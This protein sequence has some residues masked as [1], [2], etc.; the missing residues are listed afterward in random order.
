MRIVFIG[1]V[2]GSNG[3]DILRR[4]L[5]SVKKRYNADVCIVNGENSH[6]S[7]TGMTR[8]E[9]REI[10]SCGADVITGGNHSLRK[11]SMDLYEETDYILCPANF[12][13]AGEKCGVCVLDLGRDSI[14]VIN[15]IGSAFMDAHG[16]PFFRLD[17]I[18]KE[19]DVKN[20]LV[21][22][23]REATSEKAA[24]GWY[25]DGRVSRVIGTHTH[26]QTNDDTI[27]PG[28]TAYITDAGS[29][30]AMDSVLGVD[31]DAAVTKQKLHRPVRFTVRKG[32]GYMCGVF[33]E[34]DENG[35]AVRIE[36][37]RTPVDI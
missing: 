4:R 11:C 22:F 28:G 27:L 30:S 8:A 12:L 37:I 10:V 33:V 6:P 23:H 32:R 17:E 24:F 34:T 26:V 20:I 5:P 35:R 9:A 2:V 15:L 31:I 13:G 14:C 7:G 16:N 19:T 25:A 21:D 29:V 3:I 18:L 36:K 1:D